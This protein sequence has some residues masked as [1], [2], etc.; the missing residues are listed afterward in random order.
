MGF[1]S[2]PCG[3][4]GFSFPNQ[5]HVPVTGDLGTGRVVSLDIAR[6]FAVSAVCSD[7]RQRAAPIDLF[8]LPLATT[9]QNEPVR[10]PCWLVSWNC[11][12]HRCGLCW[13]P[14]PVDSLYAR[15]L[16]LSRKQAKFSASTGPWNCTKYLQLMRLSSS[17]LSR[18]VR[19]FY[20]RFSLV[21]MANAKVVC[22]QS[23]TDR[24]QTPVVCT[25]SIR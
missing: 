14:R 5:A 18:P 13:A 4:F 25:A 21:S 1:A 19:T 12:V 20:S 17:C 2:L 16:F 3:T 6:N 15:R 23:Q 11:D 7:L 10:L 24:S 22:P 9:K 8:G